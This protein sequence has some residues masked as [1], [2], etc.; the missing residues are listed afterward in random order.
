MHNSLNNSTCQINPTL[1]T[2]LLE[3]IYYKNK[4][5]IIWNLYIEFDIIHKYPFSDNQVKLWH[6]I[7][8]YPSFKNNHSVFQQALQQIILFLKCNSSQIPQI[9]TGLQIKI[10]QFKDKTHIFNRKLIKHLQLLIYKHLK[11]PNDEINPFSSEKT[12]AY[13]AAIL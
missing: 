8:V 2:W 7:I 9:E 12:I 11:P 4:K 10:L 6:V 3:N 13:K 1:I 5:I